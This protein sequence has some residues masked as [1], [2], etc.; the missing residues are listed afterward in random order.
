MWLI[1]S[2]P[3][4]TVTA[5]HGS[6]EGGP[7]IHADHRN[8]LVDLRSSFCT[9]LKQLAPREKDHGDDTAGDPPPFAR[10]YHLSKHETADYDTH[11]DR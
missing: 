11:N 9:R 4:D 3:N 2:R 7:T 1:H 5:R 6:T 8:E 10:R